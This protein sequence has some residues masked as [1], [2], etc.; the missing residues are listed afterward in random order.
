[1]LRGTYTER[2]CGQLHAFGGQYTKCC[3]HHIG[4]NRSW[5]QMGTYISPS[6]GPDL[7]I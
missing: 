4:M 1:M 5:T 7:D 2:K 3:V 6:S